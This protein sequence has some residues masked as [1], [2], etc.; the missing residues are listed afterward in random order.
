MKIL[1]IVAGDLNGGA[2]KGAYCLHKGLL[3]LG[4]DS[5]ILTNSVT[6]FGDERVVSVAAGKKGR[7]RN[8]IRGQFDS[9]SASLYRK[10]E[11]IIFST[12]FFGFDFTKTKEYK[13]ADI[14]HL[15]WI[16]NGFVNIKHLRKV[17]K[18]IVWTIRD[19]WPMTGG[20]HVAEAINCKKYKTKCGKCKQL[21]SNWSFDLSYIVHKRKRKYLPR[22]TKIVGISN[23]IA[24]KA[25]ESNLF[26]N[27]DV[28]MINNNVDSNIFYSVEK[29]V[30]KKILNL[31]TDKKVIL[32]GAGD[33]SNHWKG[34]YKFLNATKSLDKNKY[35]LCFFGKLNN[36]VIRDIKETGFEY[37]LFGY[38]QDQIS[39]RLIYSAAD[40]F[41][42]PSIMDSFGKT[43]AESMACGTPVVCFDSTGPKDIVD[44]HLNGYKAEPFKPDDLA[45]GIK[46]V[47]NGSDYE[48][49]CQNAREKVVKN[50]DSKVIAGKYKSLYKEILRK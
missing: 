35:L 33:N 17:K 40:I 15:H 29:R 47:L 28:S 18:P 34:F 10:R 6:T 27:F 25:K 26:K 4:L 45:R 31:K 21:K 7:I 5:K 2:A 12:G 48:K 36:D 22:H 50:F 14:I 23:W 20:C 49:L 42:A 43:L 13:E 30:A 9:L 8:M 24:E 3:E 32:T 41:V 44:H 46:W 16:N 11:K 37:K 19:M 39:L 38:I 1:H